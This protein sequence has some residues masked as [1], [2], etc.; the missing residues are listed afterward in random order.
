MKATKFSQYLQHR[1]ELQ[2]VDRPHWIY[3]LEA[4]IWTAIIILTGL[5]AHG[6]IAD[7]FIYPRMNADQSLNELVVTIA[8][9]IALFVKW[10]ALLYAI[11]FFTSRVIF[12][13]ST[14][15]FASDRRLYF[16]TGMIRVQVFEI[17]F[18]E[19]RKT[20]INYGWLGRF[21]G[22]GKLMLD[23]RFVEDEDLP[24]THMPE[25][26]GKLIHYNND[27]AQ[28][29]NLSLATNDLRKGRDRKE[30]VLSTADGREHIDNMHDQ[31]D[32]IHYE[33]PTERDCVERTQKKHE[34]EMDE[35][36]HHDFEDAT[37]KEQEDN[38]FKKP[39]RTGFLK[40]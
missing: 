39:A 2:F 8:A 16:K 14:F 15:I 9:Y 13:F 29:I 35:K 6:F 37:E 1:E 12:Y 23:A 19:I 21:L 38:D 22:Y 28:D 7:H 30:K 18:E 17:A 20:D 33:Y 27:L 32:A 40:T 4:G 31:M 10:G 24:Y 11:L 34:K 26:I 3:V 25:T 36:I 5:W